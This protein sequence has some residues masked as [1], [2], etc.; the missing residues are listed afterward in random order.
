MLTKKITDDKA[1]EVALYTG[2]PPALRQ[3]EDINA[4]SPL[5]EK[6]MYRQLLA[7]TV[8][9]EKQLDDYTPQDYFSDLQKG[10]ALA[11]REGAAGHAITAAKEQANLAGHLQ[12]TKDAFMPININ[13]IDSSGDLI[14]TFNVQGINDTPENEVEDAEFTCEDEL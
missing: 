4:I 14:K 12:K 1:E 9:L 11:I 6:D 10:K 2:K 8:P 3:A 7:E 13:I 5:Q